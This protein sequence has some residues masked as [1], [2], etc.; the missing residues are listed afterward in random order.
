MNTYLNI[1]FIKNKI[2]CYIYDIFLKSNNI[3]LSYFIKN[4][5]FNFYNQIINENDKKL[6]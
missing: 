1:K 4:F 5:S 2:I 6:A 3:L